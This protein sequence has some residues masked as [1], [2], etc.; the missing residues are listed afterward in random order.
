MKSRV[1]IRCAFDKE[2]TE[3]TRNYAAKLLFSA[4]KSAWK[5]P[6]GYKIIVNWCEPAL[7]SHSPIN[8]DVNF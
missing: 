2:C 5:V 1:F 6:S 3:L 4:R 7:I 8:H